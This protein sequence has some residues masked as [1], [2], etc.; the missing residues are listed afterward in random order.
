MTVQ[1]RIRG[2]KVGIVGMARS[3]MAAAKLVQ[4]LG[5]RPFVSD[6]APLEKVSSQCAEL[7]NLGIPF[8][9][10]GHTER[11]L[12]C[13]YIVVSPGALL[14]IPILTQARDT[15]LPIFSE[16]EI[17]SWVCPGRI[18]AITGANGKTTT[19]TL[20]GEIMTAAGYDTH[21]CGNIGRPLAD[22]VGLMGQDSIAVLEVSSFQLE[23]ISE[24]RPNVAAILNLTP[25]HIDRHGSFETYKQ[26]KYRITEN[27]TADDVL[28][29][30]FDDAESMADNPSSQARR[31]LF[32]AGDNKSCESFVADGWLCT[33]LGGEVRRVIAARDIA[34]KGPHNLQNASA[35]VTMAAQFDVTPEVMA[36]VLAGF[37]G[38]E[39]RL[40]RAG[41]VAGVTFIN[42]SKATN[43]DSVRWA[44]RSVE[45]PLYL[46]LGG[47]DKGGEFEL[48]AETG[49]GKI[50]GI[51]AIGEAR[52]KIFNALG[53]L[54]PTQF[55]DNLEEAI[56]KCFEMA[57]PGETVLLSPGCASFD[58]FENYEHRGRVF[59]DVVSRLRN[60]KSTNEAV[61]H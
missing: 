49:R 42:D 44:L 8:E 30:N 58:Q 21:V 37:P 54:V 57:H 6:S 5:G 50:R 43:V 10:G 17:A 22:V 29:L 40:E 16:L 39:H 51:V 45:T 27:Q 13:D 34:I 14:T 7:K 1:E 31:A 3:G 59:K 35:S 48:L 41:V 61:A 2:R 53:K 15:G 52:E 19:T 38:V 36:R 4:T 23:T 47:R 55:A 11:L 46:I 9:V 32:S 56:H 24:F 18:M 25:D 28:V 33:R 60:G 12:A 26:T 20:L